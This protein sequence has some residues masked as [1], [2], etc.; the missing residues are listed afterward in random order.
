MARRRAR[1]APAG[2]QSVSSTPSA[3]STEA[4]RHA[5]GERAGKRRPGASPGNVNRVTFGRYMNEGKRTA[6]ELRDKYRRRAEQETRRILK[7]LDLT[8]NPIARAI[9]RDRARLE[10]VVQR[11]EERLDTRGWFYRDGAPKAAVAQYIELLG[12]R[13]RETDRLL[14]VARSAQ[15]TPSLTSYLSKRGAPD[16]ARGAAPAGPS[17]PPRPIAPQSEAAATGEPS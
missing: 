17:S 6:R 7:Q 3:E 4:A 11:I 16:A 14:E 12:T 5:P 2:V 1:E 8:N 10:A 15:P 9:G 13:L